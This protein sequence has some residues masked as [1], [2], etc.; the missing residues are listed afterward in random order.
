VEQTHDAY[1]SANEDL[2]NEVDP[3]GMCGVSSVGAAL[4]SINP[5]S[6]ENCVRQPWVSASRRT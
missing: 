5:F 2:L 6:R 4:A 1:G 3:S